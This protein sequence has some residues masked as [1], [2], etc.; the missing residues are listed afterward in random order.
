MATGIDN[1]S[2]TLDFKIDENKFKGLVLYIADKCSDDPDFGATKLNKIL[3][4]SDFHSYGYWG[5]PITGA[6]YFRLKHGPAPKHMKPIRDQNRTIPLTE[7]NL[8]VFSAKEIALVDKVIEEFGG[9]NADDVS[10]VSHMEAGYKIAGNKEDIPYEAV[11][12][13]SRPLTDY[14]VQHG[15]ELAET[16]GWTI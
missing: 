12:L 1:T 9:L 13:S 6:A 3:F 11:F 8:D 7:A 14:E 4:Y 2:G 5:K 15:L 10:T 16:R